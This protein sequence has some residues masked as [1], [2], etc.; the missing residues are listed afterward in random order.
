MARRGA[1]RVAELGLGRT[2]E[3]RLL[4]IATNGLFRVGQWAEAEK[5]VAA[6]LRHRPSGADAVELLLARC[7]LSVGLRRHRGRRPGPGGGGHRTGRRRRPARAADADPARRA[8]DVGGAARRGPAG[9]PAWPDRE[10]LRR[11]GRCWP[12]WPGTAC[13]RRRRRTPAAPSPV[14]EAAV[15]R[16]RDGGR[17]GGRK[18]RTTPAA[19]CAT[20]ST[21]SSTLCAAELSRLDGRGDPE[22]WA[23]SAAEWD[24]RNHPYPAAYSRLRQAEALLARRSRVATAGKLLRQA[25]ADGAGPGRVAVERGDPYPGRPGA[26]DAGGVAGPRRRRRPRRPPARRRRPPSLRS[27]SW[28]C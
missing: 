20:S 21:A 27:T 8:G 24:R 3:T 25:Y 17:P 12:R 19:R 4:A 28:P 26:G 15:R 6:A 7:R 22:L 13:G 5:V 18:S 9:R 16:L 14:D 23:R 11:R 10:P 2:W 1:E